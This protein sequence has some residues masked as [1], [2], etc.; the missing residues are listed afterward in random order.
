[1]P[2]MLAKPRP[3]RK[4]TDYCKM[5]HLH[6]LGHGLY[7]SR[8]FKGMN[9]ECKKLGFSFRLVNLLEDARMEAL[10]RGRRPFTKKAVK[11]I[12]WDGSL[13]ESETYG[14]R[15]FNW[16]QWD[17]MNVESPANTFL[18]FIIAESTKPHVDSLRKKFE[19]V[20]KGNVS[21]FD[22][23]FA[24]TPWIKG[25]GTVKN[26]LDVI[27]WFFR[28]VAGKGSAKRYPTTESIIP[29]VKQWFDLWVDDGGGDGTCFGPGGDDV[30]AIVIKCNAHF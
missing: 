9:D 25:Y 11:E 13:C 2:D 5:V 15:K 24:H 1:M 3:K 6:E 16:H 19:D 10:M 27:E 12:S 29:L 7:T 30:S 4:E 8:D 26:Q 20:H 23:K 21:P 14:V 28:Q 18:G 22:V 17:E